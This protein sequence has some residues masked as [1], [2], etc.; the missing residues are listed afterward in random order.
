MKLRYKI[1]LSLILITAF[2]FY[3]FQTKSNLSI[4]N[5]KFYQTENVIV[6]I[7]DGPR[8]SETFGDS[9]HE[10]IPHLFKE[11][12]PAG[13]L[14]HNFKN[15]GTTTTVSGHTAITTGNYQNLKN[16]GL[17]FPRNP[18]FFQ[19]FLKKTNLT[20]D[21]A[22]II[23]SKG[24][25]NILSNAKTKKWKDTYSP[26][27]YCGIKGSGVSYEN[28]NTTWIDVKRILANY[29]PKLM[30][31]NLLEVDVRAHENDWKGYIKALKNTDE[32]AFE[33]FNLINTDNH[34]KGKT[35]L[36]ITNDH[37]RHLNGHKNGFVNH[38]DK[39][40]GCKHI[41]CIGIGP[42]FKKNY[43]SNTNYELIDISKT[44]S[45]LLYF[46]M[47]TSKGKIMTELFLD[48]K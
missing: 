23:S 9:T 28:D 2:S 8:F 5:P 48:S 38:G 19:Y 40:E 6:L 37:G 32:K 39:C 47:P 44:I 46:D 34:Y 26:M 45:E 42:D 7:I 25:L 27:S 24:K 36:I 43:K 22:W 30:L 14:F 15:N 35:T 1:I 13:V 20:K 29:H 4:S 17:D 11:I 18:S 16:N 41:Y 21:Q 3:S 12:A 31:I 33:L 10:N